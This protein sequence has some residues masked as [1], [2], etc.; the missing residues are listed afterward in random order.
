MFQVWVEYHILYVPRHQLWVI[1]IITQQQQSH[2]FEDYYHSHLFIN[3]ICLF[4]SFNYT[5]RNTIYKKKLKLLSTFSLIHWFLPIKIS[6][7]YF[8]WI[9]ICG[10]KSSA[11][12]PK[13]WPD[14]PG[15]WT[16]RLWDWSRRR[17]KTFISISSGPEGNS[18]RPR[19][20]V[21]E[22]D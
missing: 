4:L 19:I 8:Q 5:K 12:R 2:P 9:Q 11:I 7:S 20:K 14:F 17:A 15:T 13:S 6:I 3:N 10:S 22:I 18:S 21:S 16:R 1:F